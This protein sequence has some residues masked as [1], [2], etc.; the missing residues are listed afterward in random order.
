ME[1]ETTTSVGFFDKEE[2]TTTVDFLA[3]EEKTTTVDSAYFDLE[4]PTT[5]TPEMLSEE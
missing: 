4:E 1:E 2:T 5:I 3:E